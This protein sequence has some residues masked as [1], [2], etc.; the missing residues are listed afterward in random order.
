VLGACAGALHPAVVLLPV[1]LA[2][3]A[4][5]LLG[6]SWIFSIAGVLLKDLRE[7]I[8]IVLGLL[9]Y[10]SPVVLHESMVGERLWRLVLLNPLAHVVVC[11]RD[12]FQGDFHPLSWGLFLAMTALALGAGAW[13][14]GR[15]KVLINEYI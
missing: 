1:P 11:F 4:L 12:V 3:L 13:V 9:V 7:V 10:L 2:L 6:L 14:M 5:L 8:A 15:A